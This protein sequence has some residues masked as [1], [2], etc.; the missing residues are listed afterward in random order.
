MLEGGSVQGN[1]RNVWRGVFK[2]TEDMV[3]KTKEARETQAWMHEVRSMVGRGWEGWRIGVAKD[4]VGFAAFFALF[5]VSRRT[6]NSVGRSISPKSPHVEEVARDR[7]LIS[8]SR[9]VHGTILV[10]GGVV[11]GLVYEFIGRPFEVV[12]SLSR[13]SLPLCSDK[14]LNG[15]MLQ[16][17]FHRART[18]GVRSLFQSTDVARTSSRTQSCLRLL[19]R[20]G[21][22]GLAFWIWE[23]LGLGME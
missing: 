23:A 2:G 22:W 15:N 6:A 20:V 21:P 3:M 10:T 13:P 18:R 9:I 1:W 5:D 7:R 11:A 14:L 8:Y 16:V 17:A 12:R 4:I 19:G